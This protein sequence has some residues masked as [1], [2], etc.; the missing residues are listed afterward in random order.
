MLIELSKIIAKAGI[1]DYPQFRSGDTLA[2]H[3]RIKEGNK[4]RVQIFQGM[5]IA[6]RERGHMGGHFRVRKIS[7][8]MGVERVFP[9]HS[10]NVEKIEVVSR[11]KLVGPSIIICVSVRANL[12]V[13]QWTTVARTN[14]LGR[15]VVGSVG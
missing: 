4:S 5:C 10:P 8:G 9:F 3:V 2:V 12:R 1:E 7:S 15:V 14:G 13:L 11:G 6:L